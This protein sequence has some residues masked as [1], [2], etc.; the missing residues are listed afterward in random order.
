VTEREKKKAKRKRYVKRERQEK[1]NQ[2]EINGD[3]RKQKGG[4]R[5]TEEERD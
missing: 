3:T 2:K 5:L 1:R 4:K